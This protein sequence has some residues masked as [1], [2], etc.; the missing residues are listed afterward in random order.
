[1]CDAL[2][3]C[4]IQCIRNLDIGRRIA[5]VPMFGTLNLPYVTIKTEVFFDAGKTFRRCPDLPSSK[6][7]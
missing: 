1:M 3:M 6:E 7:N 5:T 2:T 4:F